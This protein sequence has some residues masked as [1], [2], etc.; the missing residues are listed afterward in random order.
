MR[1]QSSRCP[2]LLSLNL[3]CSTGNVLH[4]TGNLDPHA[5]D[6]ILKSGH[7]R[8]AAI[9]ASDAYLATSGDDKILKVWQLDGLKLLSVRYVS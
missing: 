5:K 3:F 1:A 6:A 4:S 8:C 9:D 2:F 7:V